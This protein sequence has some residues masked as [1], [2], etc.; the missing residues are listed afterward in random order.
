MG[1]RPRPGSFWRRAAAVLGVLMVGAG[2]VV[3]LRSRPTGDVDPFGALVG[4][5][6][7][8]IGVAGLLLPFWEHRQSRREGAVRALVRAV[9][10]HE[11]QQYR[12]ILGPGSAFLP[13]RFR[14]TAAPDGSPD[15]AG[16]EEWRTV[17]DR[18]LGL[19]GPVRR[20]AVTGGPGT[21]KSLLAR[22]LTR[23]L[24]ARHDEAAGDGVPVLLSLSSWDGPPDREDPRSEG[25]H[26]AFRRWAVQQAAQT[27]GQP[28]AQV[29]EALTDKAVL[30]L[31]GLDELDPTGA[32]ARPRAA[33][34]LRYLAVN[35]DCFRHVVVTCRSDVYER[36][37]GPA[38]LAGAGRAELLPVPPDMALD[39]LKS[40]SEWSH[41]GL[42]ER[43]DGVLDEMRVSPGGPLA[44]ALSTP[45]RL[46]MTA[47]AFHVRGEG[48]AGWLRDPSE[49]VTR[50]GR[51]VLWE[52]YRAESEDFAAEHG[53][54]GRLWSLFSPEER[55]RS[56]EDSPAADAM[57][58]EAEEYL[59]SLFVPSVVAEHPR[60]PDRYPAE[61]VSAWLT[62]LS[63][64]RDVDR[65]AGPRYL[66]LIA[67]LR[68]DLT[69]HQLWPLGG[70]RLVRTLHGSL[71]TLFAL[72]V[73]GLAVVALRDPLEVALCFPVVVAAGFSAHLA[74]SDR[75]DIDP[76]SRIR[77]GGRAGGLLDLYM[78]TVGMPMLG[79]YSG[80]MFGFIVSANL[81]RA[82]LP[83]VPTTVWVATAAGALLGIP[84][85][86]N[87]SAETYTT[88]RGSLP[89]QRHKIFL[90]CAAL[91]GRLP[92]RLGRFLD[93]A[94]EGGL[95]RVDG[96]AY[97]FRHDEFE[98]YLW[99][100]HWRPEILPPC[101]AAADA[102]LRTGEAAADR[103][104]RAGRRMLE[105]LDTLDRNRVDLYATCMTSIGIA[106]AR[107]RT[108][109]RAWADHL[110]TGAVAPEAEAVLRDRAGQAVRSFHEAAA[111]A[112]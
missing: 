58:S 56:A 46:T 47:N 99:R 102:A 89:G 35:R 1:R 31:D 26:L 85:L 111:R 72:L 8:V 45:W 70:R 61:R 84:L 6:G 71:Y 50:W 16:S 57:S 25:F 33:A 10:G 9:E 15:A 63:T 4:V 7:A 38:P 37:E 109:L 75:A 66:S 69:P 82:P 91:S 18:Y 40:R 110:A 30:V 73:A 76:A 74:W 43:W 107:A 19:P 20:L 81:T 27:Y 62:L 21:G 106:G 65:F 96:H 112:G 59:L 3:I 87:R 52:R 60:D 13:V 22:E 36:F 92:L 88:V 77:M 67:D 68:A 5:V 108:A 54:P 2:A 86:Q 105:Q 44:R 28:S 83:D 24:A 32:E 55:L 49:L 12:N 41:S 79:V 53:L 11:D 103:P 23:A 39:Y 51:D 94:H 17:V 98:Q 64:H 34:L 29:E 100:S 42:T 101:L 78:R 104:A 93:W 48:G 95:L 80:G 14:F 97:R 90:I